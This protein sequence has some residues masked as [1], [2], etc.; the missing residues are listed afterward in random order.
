MEV[1][2][3]KDV[4]ENYL[5]DQFPEIFNLTASKFYKNFG[6]YPGTRLINVNLRH[7]YRMALYF[8][9]D[10]FNIVEAF[11][12]KLT[13]SFKCMGCGC[14]D[15]DCR[16]CVDKT[17]EPCHW[18]REDLCSACSGLPNYTGAINTLKEAAAKYGEKVT[19]Q[20]YDFDDS[21]K[22]KSMVIDTSFLRD[23]ERGAIKYVTQSIKTNS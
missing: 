4:L 21:W 8:N 11:R 12:S 10:H 18:V 3:V 13:K 5:G 19:C 14:T 15:D 9:D 23:F 22:K 2:T 6:C 20:F 7:T 17:G 1:S 16:Q